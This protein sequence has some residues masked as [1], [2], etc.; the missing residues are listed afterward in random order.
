MNSNLLNVLKQIIVQNGETVLSDPI[1]VSAFLNDLAKD[2]PKPQKNAL[3]KSLEQGFAQMLKNVSESERDNC[4][5]KLARRL[6]DE[7]GLDLHLCGETVE[8][9]A[10]VLFGEEEAKKAAG[11]VQP[12]IMR[13]LEYKLSCSFNAAITEFSRAIE[14]DSKNEDAY[15][16]RGGT[17]GNLGE[18]GKAIA[19]YTHAITLSQRDANYVSRGIAYFMLEKFNES[20]SDLETALRLNPDN[21]E[22]KMALKQLE[23][24][25]Y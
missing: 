25:G 23:S 7:E 15:A 14:L 10:A 16:F 6:R 24:I 2:E 9:L 5:Q 13:G 12:H 11:S 17:Y 4:K 22:A 20:R 1:R 18:W 21:D 19:D 3:V 8:L